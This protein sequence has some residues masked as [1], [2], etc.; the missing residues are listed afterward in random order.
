MSEIIDI[1]H[2]RKMWQSDKE[3]SHGNYQYDEETREL[4]CGKC[5]KEVDKIEVIFR[6]NSCIQAMKR[7]LSLHKVEMEKIEKRKRVKCRHCKK[8][9]TLD[10]NLTWADQY[11]YRN[12]TTRE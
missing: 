5:K 7:T 10:L 11:K 8:F 4:F 2:F 6:L 9:T 3:C 12:E 1:Q